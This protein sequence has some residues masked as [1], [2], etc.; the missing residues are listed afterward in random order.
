[1]QAVGI[2]IGQ[3]DDFP[4]AQTGNLAR[5]RIHAD[6]DRN[7]VNFLVTEHGVRIHFPGIQ[8]FAPQREYGLIF[9]VAGLLGGAAG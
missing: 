3:D 4:V 9:T 1:M 2:R 5:T 6:G 8:D 7:I